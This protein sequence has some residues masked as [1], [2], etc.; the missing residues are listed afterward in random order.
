MKIPVIVLSGFLGSGKT[1]LLLRL[2]AAA[3]ATGLQT[4]VIMNELGQLDVDGHI[5]KEYSGT[6]VEKLL[7]GCVCCS[8][9]S[10]LASSI[11]TLC[12]SRPDVIFIELTGV[13]NPEEIA[14]VLTEPE[15]RASVHLK[16]IVTVFD[17]ENVL[18]YNSFFESDR[19]LIRTLR[20]QM[21]T[22]DILVL[23][24]TD[25]ASAAKRKKIGE[26]LLK[27]NSTAVVIPATHSQ[28]N[29]A[30]MLADIVKEERQPASAAA[31]SF[32][33]LKHAPAAGSRSHS[34]H[35]SRTG[36][37]DIET[38]S[39]SRV[40]TLSISL[41]EGIFPGRRAVEKYLQKN[42]NQLLR[43]KGYIRL[44]PNSPVML[45]QLAGNQLTWTETSRQG[46]CYLVLIGIDLNKQ[47]LEEQWRRVERL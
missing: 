33:I 44:Q 7:D 3:E 14:D 34:L 17:A 29:P 45:L 5:L 19:A 22:A 40:Q 12:L 1:T 39:F 9:R 11:Q 31:S 20:R 41:A 38:A 25:L 21:E 32:R 15:I 43:A 6:K 16:Q 2:L 4:G 13:A 46:E 35:S 36:H 10:E 30:L 42:K 18:D 47:E 23:N 28:V 27:H 37:V 8:K 24:K 26:L